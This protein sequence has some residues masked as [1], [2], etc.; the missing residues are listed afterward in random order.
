M[1]S[2]Y[3]SFQLV[4]SNENF[5]QGFTGVP[6]ASDASKLFKQN[7]KRSKSDNVSKDENFTDKPTKERQEELDLKRLRSSQLWKIK[8]TKARKTKEFLV[9]NYEEEMV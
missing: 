4:N 5:C 7:H 8:R 2:Y 1:D 6:N 9:Q 3:V